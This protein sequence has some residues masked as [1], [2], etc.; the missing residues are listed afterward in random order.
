MG[1]FESRLSTPDGHSVQAAERREKRII[2]SPI[3]IARN[4]G[5][6]EPRLTDEASSKSDLKT[7]RG[8]ICWRVCAPWS[9]WAFNRSAYDFCLCFQ[10]GLR[11][12]EHLAG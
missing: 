6:L 10:P 4:A 12:I 7:H 5:S 1:Q 2:R 11:L 3:K 8:I 9:T